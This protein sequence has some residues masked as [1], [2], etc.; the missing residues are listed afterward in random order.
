MSQETNEATEEDETPQTPPR[1]SKSNRKQPKPLRQDP[2]DP[3][4]S[5]SGRY[6]F[7]PNPQDPELSNPNG[8]FDYDPSIFEAE[9]EDP[10]GAEYRYFPESFLFR[11]AYK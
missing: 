1:W 5:K 11:D 2:N 4:V 3:D 9:P 8:C 10:R 7:E 6:T